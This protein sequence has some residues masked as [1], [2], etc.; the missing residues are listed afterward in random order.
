MKLI[1]TNILIRFFSN[2]LPVEAASAKQLL[3]SCKAGSLIVTDYVLAELCFVLEFNTFYRY[4]RDRGGRCLG[5]LLDLNSVHLSVFAT[6][7][8]S[9]YMDDPKLD[10]TD[11]LLLAQSQIDSHDLMTLDKHLAKLSSIK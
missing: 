1:D 4:P 7:A 3:T 9:Y 2:D 10:M 6:K 8:I 11:C 5:V